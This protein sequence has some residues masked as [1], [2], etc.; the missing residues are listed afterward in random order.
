MDTHAALYARACQVIPGGVNSPVRAFN[1]VGGTP[2]AVASGKGSHI[3]LVDGR[4]LIDCCCSWGA[5]ILGHADPAVTAAVTH[6]AAHGTTFG[7]GTP[8]EVALAERLV[9]AIPFIDK[10]RLVNSGTEAVMSAIRL[11][12]GVTGR[13]LIIKCEG[14]YH[15]H[16][17]GLLVRSGSGTLTA[18]DG[19][20]VASAG[21]PAQVAADTLVV[22]YNDAAAVA[23]ALE[24]HAGRVAAVIVEPVA[25]NMGC[26]PPRPGYLQELEAVTHRAGA[27]L[28]CDEVIN[29]FRFRYG[30]YSEAA[31]ITPDI[32]TMGKVIGGGFPLAALGAKAEI[33]D[34]LAPLGHVY[35]AGTL[36]GN[37]V[38]V[39]AACVVLDALKANPPY[40][41]MAARA[42]RIERAFNAAAQRAGVPFHVR[43][44]E[45][46]FTPFATD[47]AP[48]DNFAQTQ[49]CDCGRY[50]RF[51]HGMLRRGVYL[52]PSQY[53]VNFISAAHSDAD[54][55]T[56]IA[57]AEATLAEL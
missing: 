26:V 41:A 5:M 14:C 12:R 38:A 7:I 45:T 35:Q 33:M 54:V 51:F 57:A 30:L 56:L 15:G 1:A 31:G 36:S 4:T 8:G 42:E 27:L 23:C 46:I 16:S 55:E 40:A 29:A 11:A 37:P 3:T 22:P 28:I 6:A 2:I 25:G 53:E 39:A 49:A 32:V 50:A 52:A 34:A 43:R 18:G 17:D 10:V 44:H 21:I 20:E 9:E 48:I 24:A 19:A 47:R 13:D